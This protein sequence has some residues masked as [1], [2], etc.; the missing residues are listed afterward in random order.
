[1]LIDVGFE[2]SEML[3][4][5]NLLVLVL[6][7]VIVLVTFIV[8]QF[9]RSIISNYS[10][11]VGLNQNVEN[12]L[13]FIV[14]ILVAFGGVAALLQYLGL[15]LD[16]LFGLSALAGAAVG[17]ASTQTLGNFL[18][19]LYLMISRPFS[20]QDYVRIGDVEGEVI[21][22]S[23]NYTSIYNTTYNLV[24]IPNRKILD[25]NI[26]NYTS[27]DGLL[28]YSY[29]IG[30]P[31]NDRITNKEIIDRCIIP[32]IEDFYKEHSETLPQKP[33]YGMSGM[34]RLEREFLIRLFFPRGRTTEFYDTQ[35][36]LTEKIVNRWDN[37]VKEK[38]EYSS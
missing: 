6:S 36:L 12:I 18:A 10:G 5:Q 19:G 13:K 32:G 23:I 29:Q 30:F 37:L 11:R 20:I 33:E 2:L 16:W 17:F 14:R 31:H 26:I 9:F 22:I 21:S 27:K 38:I 4:F 35:P 34:T 8:D 3:N 15:G 7:I 28:D 25:S 1:M 24:E